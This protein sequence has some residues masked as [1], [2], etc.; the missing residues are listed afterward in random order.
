MAKTIIHDERGNAKFGDGDH[1]QVAQTRSF[2]SM[3]FE[4]LSEKVP[5]DP[6]LKIFELLLNLSID[7]GSETPS[8]IKV[9]E[10]AKEGKT[11]SESVAAGILEINDTHG[12][13]GEPLMELLYRVK[14]KGLSVKELV[15]EYLQEGKRLP[16][17]GH[18]IYKGDDPRVLLI[19]EK[20]AELN[21]DPEFI[22]I[23]KEI[24]DELEKQKGTRLP[25][26]IDGAIAAV[27]CSFGWEP[28]L[29]K[30]FFV[31]ART[32]G[33]VGQYLNNSH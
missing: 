26:N 31:A 33:L 18:R 5:S 25:I 30:A 22:N 3:V 7:H 21:I 17:L 32:P 9:V 16:G 29:G 2:A 4:L 13:A 15:A 23:L 19:F 12:G 11:I 8:A 14:R 20:A 27:L 10:A 6:E 28:R 24:Q 1:L